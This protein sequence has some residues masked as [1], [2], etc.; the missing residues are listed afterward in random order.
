MPERRLSHSRRP[1]KLAQPRDDAT[2][3][4]A[5]AAAAVLKLQ[6]IKM[7]ARFRDAMAR[8]A[9]GGPQLGNALKADVK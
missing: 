9:S 7:D 8:A 3:D 4:D 1:S 5:D 2:T 6:L